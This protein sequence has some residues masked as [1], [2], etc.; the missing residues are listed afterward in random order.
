MSA[1][2]DFVRRIRPL[3]CALF[4]ILALG[5]TVL[6]FTLNNDPVK[7]YEAPEDTAYYAAHPEALVAELEAH[8]FPALEG[9]ERARVTED[10][11]VLVTLEEEHYYPSRGAILQYFDVSL[12]EFRQEA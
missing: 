10:G 1:G 11:K 7:G 8:I 6:C 5:V 2:E 4:L 3:G 12:L 9:E